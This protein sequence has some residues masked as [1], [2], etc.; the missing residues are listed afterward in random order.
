[1]IWLGAVGL[2]IYS[3]YPV[4]T[5]VRSVTFALALGLLL[6]ALCLPLLLK[7]LPH[8]SHPL[9]NKLR[10]AL[11]SY[12]G[13]LGAIAL[14]LAFSLIVHLIQAW[15]HVIMGKALGLEVPFSFCLILYPLVGTFAAIPVSFNGIGL[16]ESA[17]MF[18]LGAIGISSEMAIAFGL[19]LLAIV[20]L[21]SLL[22]GLLFL[23]TRKEN[24]S[25][26]D[27]ETRE[28]RKHR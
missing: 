1:L 24:S 26:P 10:V 22:G 13:A 28:S 14:A 9:I 5:A 7:F 3:Q 23:L 11:N 6:G 2:V 16:R 4:P 25:S 18:L 27:R 19:L 17:Y 15:M 20:T 21:D 12:G 8:D